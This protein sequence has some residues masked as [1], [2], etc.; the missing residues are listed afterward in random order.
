MVETES[1]RGSIGVCAEAMSPPFV[2]LWTDG[3]MDA[4]WVDIAGELCLATASEFERTARARLGSP[5]AIR[6]V[7]RGRQ[8][9]LFWHG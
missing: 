1:A 2:S 5:A 6:M 9:Q 4:V 3:E 8:R 7:E